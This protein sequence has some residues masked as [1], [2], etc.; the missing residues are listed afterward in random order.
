MLREGIEAI[1]ESIDLD[2]LTDPS[3]TKIEG[4]PNS[5]ALLKLANAFMGTD[6]D[7]LA[8]ARAYLAKDMSQ[9]AVVDAVGVA[10]NFQRMVRIADSTGIPSDDVMLIMAEDL[11][12]TLGINDY[13]SAANS[14]KLFW[15]K[16][17]I[18]KI[19]ALPQVK[20]VIKD[21]TAKE[22]AS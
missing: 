3:C 8:E 20:K 5:E 16:K 17:L 10:S 4:I 13:V 15:L 18:L 12:E 14:K 19:V 6:T 21:T 2:G 7:A 22:P 11:C 9:E 1:G